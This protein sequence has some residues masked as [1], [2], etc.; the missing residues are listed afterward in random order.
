M[1]RIQRERFEKPELYEKLKD[2]YIISKDTILGKCKENMII[3]HPL[4]RVNEIN[5]D[6]DDTKHALYF[7]QAKNGVPIREA[8]IG[9]ALDKLNINYK[10][11]EKNEIIYSKEQVCENR[12]CITKFEQTDNKVEIINGKKFC[13]YCGREI[14]K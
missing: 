13:Y 10:E 2:V 8:M 7:K 12:N 6:L 4:P 9:I 1:T 14:K 3:L 11:K 5:I